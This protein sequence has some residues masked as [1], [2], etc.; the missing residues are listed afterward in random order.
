MGFV[1]VYN[2]DRVCI[3]AIQQEE[4]VQLGRSSATLLTTL[5]L[6]CSSICIHGIINNPSTPKNRLYLCQ[7]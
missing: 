5:T 1:S 4:W 2:A 3:Y 6:S 7:V